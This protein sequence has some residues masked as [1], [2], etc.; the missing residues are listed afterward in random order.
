VQEG[1]KCCP[2]TTLSL[3]L[4]SHAYAKPHDQ[5][6]DKLIM[7]LL[8]VL[9]IAEVIYQVGSSRRAWSRHVCVYVCVMQE[10]PNYGPST[11]LSRASVSQRLRQDRP[12]ERLVTLDLPPDRL[13]TF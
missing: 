2:G 5:P 13:V 10:G 6:P 8:S 11:T 3:A 1:P 7:V 12:P 4:R 9:L